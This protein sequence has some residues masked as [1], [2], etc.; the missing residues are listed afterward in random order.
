MPIG[1]MLLNEVQFYQGTNYLGQIAT[2]R[3]LFSAGGIDGYE[4]E[5]GKLESLVDARLDNARATPNMR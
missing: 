4:A 2:S 3:G 5:K 1:I